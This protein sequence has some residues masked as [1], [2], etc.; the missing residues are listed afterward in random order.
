MWCTHLVFGCQRT[1]ILQTTMEENLAMIYDT[2]EYAV[3]QHGRTL[4]VDLE[5]IF[6]GYKYNAENSLQC[7]RAAMNGGASCL[8]LCDKWR[9]HAMGNFRHCIRIVET[10][11]WNSE[12]GHSLSQ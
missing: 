1:D 9:D 2:V 10:I 8:V 6:D 11:G 3:R 5:H 12:I 7:C 4:M